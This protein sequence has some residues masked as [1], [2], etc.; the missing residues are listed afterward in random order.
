VLSSNRRQ[1][2]ERLL[3]IFASVLCRG[4][5]TLPRSDDV[6]SV[7][8]VSTDDDVIWSDAETAAFLKQSLP[9]F[10]KHLKAGLGPPFMQ[11]GRFRQYRPAAVRQWRLSKERS[12]ERPPAPR[13]G[14]PKTV[15]P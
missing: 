3:H 10:R 12:S 5:S 9:T 7:T 13:R 1:R 4:Y 6:S 8:S 11:Y 15:R 2:S 14:R